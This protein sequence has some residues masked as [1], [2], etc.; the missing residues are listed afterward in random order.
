MMALSLDD[1]ENIFYQSIVKMKIIYFNKSRI[2]NV[3]KHT[4][5]VIIL[6]IMMILMLYLNKIQNI[7]IISIYNILDILGFNYKMFRKVFN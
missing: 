5:S 1:A 4:P 6:I 3:D 2:F 7:T